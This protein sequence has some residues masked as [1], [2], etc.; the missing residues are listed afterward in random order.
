[1]LPRQRI[2]HGMLESPLK[3]DRNVE[4]TVG[5]RPKPVAQR[6]AESVAQV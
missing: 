1:M 4:L 5:L 2:I 6:T 3:G